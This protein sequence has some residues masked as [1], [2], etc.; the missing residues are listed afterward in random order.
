MFPYYDDAFFMFI[1]YNIVTTKYHKGESGNGEVLKHKKAFSSLRVLNIGNKNS[2]VSP[3][4]LVVL[5]HS[6]SVNHGL[7]VC[8]T[9]AAGNSEPYLC[10]TSMSRVA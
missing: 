4:Q 7:I 2:C 6:D 8:Y 1:F 10:S 9:L 3:K 5:F